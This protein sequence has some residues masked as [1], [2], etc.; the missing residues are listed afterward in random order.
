MDISYV[1]FSVKVYFIL[2]NRYAFY[3]ILCVV[4][5][6]N[7]LNAEVYSCNEKKEKKKI[8]IE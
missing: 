8:I 2:S 3:G 4:L 6:F 1:Y 7:G 5:L